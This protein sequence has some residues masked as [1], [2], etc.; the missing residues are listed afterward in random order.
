LRRLA[1]AKNL[2]GHG[3]WLLWLDREFGWTDKTAER[4][5]SVYR[6]G[7]K[8]DNL[9]DLQVPVSSLYLLAAPST[10]EAARDAV[11]EVA[12]DGR[13]THAQVKGI[14]GKAVAEARVAERPAIEMEMARRA[15]ASAGSAATLSVPAPL[16]TSAVECAAVM[17]LC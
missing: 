14:V 5:M 8:I 16:A 10:P 1:E 9:S 4:F 2:A 11:I 13:L 15:G 7:T 3:G 6:L 12:T 17:R